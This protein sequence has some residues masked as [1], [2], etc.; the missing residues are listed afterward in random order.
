MARRAIVSRTG[1]R[2]AILSSQA[3]ASSPLAAAALENPPLL[4]PLVTI[5]AVALLSGFLSHWQQAQG[6]REVAAARAADGSTWIRTVDGWEPSIVL[7]SQPD[8]ATPPTLHPL[9]VA[10]FFLSASLLALLAFPGAQSR[11]ERL[12][13]AEAD[14]RPARRR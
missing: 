12:A 2:L 7:E 8:P 3:A 6:Q 4:R 13:A 9:L 1:T 14:D 5:A 10:G 11:A